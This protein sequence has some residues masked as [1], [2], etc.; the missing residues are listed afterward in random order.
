[1]LAWLA[2][3]ARL[4]WLA[5]LAL[6]LCLLCLL[7]LLGLLGLPPKPSAASCLRPLAASCLRPLGLPP[8]DDPLGC[9]LPT[10]PCLD[11]LGYHILEFDAVLAQVAVLTP[12]FSAN[13]F[14]SHLVPS[15][16][17]ISSSAFVFLPLTPYDPICRQQPTITVRACEQSCHE[18]AIPTGN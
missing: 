4:A 14:Y 2:W 9:L 12:T 17:P 1:M 3:F 6:L 7:G 10:T 5:W 15:F 13:N 11:F 8:A 18:Q 16:H